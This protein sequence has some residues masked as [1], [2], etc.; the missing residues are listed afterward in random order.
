MPETTTDAK[1]G[2]NYTDAYRAGCHSERSARKGAQSRNRDHPGRAMCHSERSEESQSSRERAL[3]FRAQRG[4]AIVPREGPLILSR[5]R[6]IV[7]PCLS[8]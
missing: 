3:S 8:S 6:R 5:Q 7:I 2:A 4:I 1:K